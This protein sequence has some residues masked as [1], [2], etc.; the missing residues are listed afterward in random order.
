MASFYTIDLKMFWKEAPS[1]IKHPSFKQQSSH[2]A[3]P[4]TFSP[5]I[6]NHPFKFHYSMSWTWIRQNESRPS[7]VGTFLQ[8]FK[9]SQHRGLLSKQNL[10]GS[11]LSNSQVILAS[12]LWTSSNS[13]TYFFKCGCGTQGGIYDKIR[14]FGTVIN[15]T[16]Y[17]VALHCITGI[18]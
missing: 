4:G 5:L 1:C 16:S 6:P 13:S 11:L 12:F 14:I 2:S 17:S 10:F 15:M 8:T 9:E 3:Y 18:R 7:S